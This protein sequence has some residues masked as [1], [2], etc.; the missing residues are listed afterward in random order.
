[1]QVKQRPSETLRNPPAVAADNTSR[2]LGLPPASAKHGSP[3]SVEGSPNANHALPVQQAESTPKAESDSHALSSA[4]HP[5]AMS[6]PAPDVA[7]SRPPVAASH[8][9]P[10]KPRPFRTVSPSSVSGASGPGAEEMIRAARASD[11]EARAAWLWKAVSKGNRQAPIELA[12]M[13][14]QGSGVVRSC[15]Q[16]Q[17]LLRSAAAHGNKEAKLNLELM[18]IRGSCSVR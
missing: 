10:A 8:S 1:M 4:N 15:D 16:A 14:E 3:Q 7:E 17:V 9:S 12:R 11:A 2:D 6:A 13:Y 18:H 5:P